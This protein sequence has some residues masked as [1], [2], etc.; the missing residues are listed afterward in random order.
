[1]KGI[2]LAGGKGTRLLPATKL[3][4]K[5]LVAILN[6]PMILYPLETLRA[7]GA[8]EVLIVSG[9]NHI[10]MFAD[11]LSD[12]SDYGVDLTYKVQREAGGI[13]QALGIAEQFAGRESVLVCLGDN[14]F[15]NEVLKK[16]TFRKDRA[17]IFLKE[18]NDPERFGVPTIQDGNIICITEKPSMPQSNFAVV[19]LYFYPNDV[20]DAV[21]T[22]KPSARGELE[23]TDLNNHYVRNNRCDY[24]ILDGFWSDAGT[25]SSLFEVVQWAGSK[26][27]SP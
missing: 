15:D 27:N 8:K 5:H 18:V 11:F 16:T 12:G 24:V 17:T 2:V 1:M 14:V 20:F 13:A 26:L 6:K 19:G 9:G 21:K 3:Y 25:P 10:G 23:I 7:L 4:N 22:L